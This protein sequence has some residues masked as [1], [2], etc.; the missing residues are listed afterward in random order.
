MS[1]TSTGQR[2]AWSLPQAAQH[3]QESFVAECERHKRRGSSHAASSVPVDLR[4]RKARG[5]TQT[6]MK[7]VC[8]SLYLGELYPKIVAVF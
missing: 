3:M 5:P 6:L 7:L 1:P 2:E 4:A 8:S